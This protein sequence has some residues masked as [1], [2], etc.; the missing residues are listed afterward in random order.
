M[1]TCDLQE[2]D[3]AVETTAQNDDDAEDLPIADNATMLETAEAM[4]AAAVAEQ[5]SNAVATTT[6]TH[7][8][9]VAANNVSVEANNDVVHNGEDAN[10][11][12]SHGTSSDVSGVVHDQVGPADKDEATD[13]GGEPSPK[14]RRVEESLD[15]DDDDPI[16]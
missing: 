15:F 5:Q 16:E 11:A 7:E 13:G 4:V 2:D 6:T 12:A 10:T 9:S 8:V 3:F 14:V 1:I